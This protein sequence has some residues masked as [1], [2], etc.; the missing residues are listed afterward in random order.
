MANRITIPDFDFSGFYYPQL[1]EA[2][3]LYKRQ[4]VPELT[5]ESAYE[6]YSQLL[7]AFALVGHLN[8]TLLD[9]VA[10]E[11]TL[12]T[13]QLVETVRNML[14]LIDFEMRPAT[15]AQADLIYELSGVLAAATEVVP[16]GAQAA[17]SKEGDTPAIFFE[18]LEALTVDPTNVFSHVLTWDGSAFTDQTTKANDQTPGQHF[19]IWPGGVAV[20]KAVYFGHKQIMWNE[21]GA[22]FQTPGSNFQGVWEFYD[23][24]WT[25]T[26][27]TSVSDL[28]GQLE[29]DLTSLLGSQNRQGT[30]VRIQL[31][32]TTAY[33]ELESTWTGTKNIAVTGLLGQ[34]SP[35]TDPEDYFVGSD[36]TILEALVD[37]SAG[38]TQDGDL[39]FTLPQTV[40]LDWTTGAVNNKTAFW[41]RFRVTSVLGGAVSPVLNYALLTGGKQY[42]KRLVTQG[43]TIEE[44]LGS[45]NGST[46]QRFPASQDHFVWGSEEISVDGETW[47]RVSNFL[48]STAR[49]KHYRTELSDNDQLVVV[50]GDGVTGRIPP[51][52]VSNV[53]ASYR[54]GANEDGNVG[55]NKITSD[56][57]GLVK[58]NKVWNPRPAVG[59]E[60]AQGATES[61]L[62]RAKIEG[63]ASLRVKEVALSPDDLVTLAK[64][65]ELDG[66]RPFARGKA[67]EEGYGPKTVALTVVAAGGGQASA[68]QL[69]ALDAYFNGD[70]TA[71]PKIAK[72]FVANQEVTSRN[73]TPKTID[74]AASVWGNVS[75]EAVE[76]SLREV[77]QPEALREDGVTY[78]WDFGET[79]PVSRLTHEIFSTDESIVKVEITEINGAAPADVSMGANQLPFLGT[80]TLQIFSA[81]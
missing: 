1:L 40:E 26:N 81:S 51:V 25:K 4:N 32:E 34:T 15:P 74:I 43:K 2:L 49:D 23:G 27:P 50:F 7:R 36:W 58:V 20:G 28:G 16:E 48:A 55:A 19:T 12:P 18:A 46:N 59:W 35:S 5:D 13:S 22:V 77:V 57:S 60:Q 53:S 52:G 21:L 80:V 38:L 39:E 33:E 30:T 65:F 41:L 31:N 11:H 64:A 14:R 67:F 62:E 56:K 70:P 78:E 47:V 24:R 69:E 17:T 71:S 73:Y 42:A 8:N 66:A 6:P 75:A 63:P 68:A 9:L 29:F 10:Q 37:G 44:T 72:H 54:W 45:S 79:V 76:N 3:T 61:S